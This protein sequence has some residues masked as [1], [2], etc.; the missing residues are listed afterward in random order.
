MKKLLFLLF[1]LSSIVSQAQQ[2][3]VTTWEVTTGDLD[4][5]IPTNT[6]DYTYDYTID[7]GDGT[8]LNNQTG[9]VT[10]T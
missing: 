4:I 5:T 8:V 9:D 10:H 6:D 7:L 2:P 3:F 1:S